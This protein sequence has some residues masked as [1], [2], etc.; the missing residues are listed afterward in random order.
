[1]TEYGS[2]VSDCFG[3]RVDLYECGV[4]G[5]KRRRNV[6]TSKTLLLLLWVFGRASRNR[7]HP[8]FEI[9]RAVSE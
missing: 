2:M 6:K 4:R 1:M 8:G 7:F 3:E 9:P 5:G